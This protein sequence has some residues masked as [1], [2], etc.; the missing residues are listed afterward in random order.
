MK[1]GGKHIAA[2]KM[3][4][5]PPCYLVGDTHHQLWHETKRSPPKDV[6]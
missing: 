6:V 4:A 3:Q 2:A 1:K 5:V